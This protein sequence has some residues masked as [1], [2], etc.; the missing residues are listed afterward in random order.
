MTLFYFAT[1]KRSLWSLGGPSGPLFA[2]G[3]ARPNSITQELLKV[4]PSE[5]L[6][7][8]YIKGKRG[9][10]VSLFFVRDQGFEPWTH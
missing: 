6:A 8:T 1:Q 7:R 4:F 9:P 10:K 3:L 5:S 2:R